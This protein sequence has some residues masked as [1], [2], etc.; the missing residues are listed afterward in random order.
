MPFVTSSMSVLVH[1]FYMTTEAQLCTDVQWPVRLIH[2]YGYFDMSCGLG[3]NGRRSIQL[4]WNGGRRTPDSIYPSGRLP[5]SLITRVDPTDGFALN[6]LPCDSGA[7]QNRFSSCRVLSVW[8]FWEMQCISTLRVERWR[9]SDDPRSGV[10][11]WADGQTLNQ[12][13][14][15]TRD[16]EKYLWSIP[17]TEEWDRCEWCCEITR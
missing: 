6:E 15:E 4:A 10:L 16:T 1:P 2:T 3:V 5:W 8:C 9:T 17:V 7:I 11:V 12:N 13:S 14:E